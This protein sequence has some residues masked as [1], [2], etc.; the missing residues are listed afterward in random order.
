MWQ[1]GVVKAVDMWILEEW[2]CNELEWASEG[3]GTR[4]LGMEVFQ[5]SSGAYEIHQ[6]GYI[7]DLLRSH[8]MHDCPG[9]LLPC[10]KEELPDDVSPEPED[11]SESELRFGQRMVG[12]QLWLTMRCRPDLQFVVGHM[13]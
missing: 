8:G 9:T 10:P 4:Y 13:A 12:E 11:F 7:L 3:G 6:K 2:P 5:R 1:S